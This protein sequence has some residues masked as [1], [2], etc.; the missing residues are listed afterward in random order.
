MHKASAKGMSLAEEKKSLFSG[1]CF[2]ARPDYDLLSR[3]CSQ[4][5]R[6]KNIDYV[7]IAISNAFS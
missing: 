2:G 3:T 7:C 4:H 6:T 5:G 1:T